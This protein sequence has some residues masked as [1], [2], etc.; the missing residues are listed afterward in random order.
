MNKISKRMKGRV[1]SAL[2]LMAMGVST[3][4]QGQEVD[5]MSRLSVEQTTIATATPPAV[6][7]LTLG[8]EFNKARYQQGEWANLK[9]RVEQPTGQNAYVALVQAYPDGRVVQLFPNQ[10][11]SNNQVMGN[12]TF[13]IRGARPEGLYVNDQPG[14]YLVKLIAS[15]DSQ[16]LNNV[17]ASTTKASDLAKNLQDR[18]YLGSAGSTVW[19]TNGIAYEVVGQA[20]AQSPG[21]TS[22]PMAPAVQPV[23]QPMGVQ[24]ML[25]MFDA[26]QSDFHVS[27]TTKNNQQQYRVGDA[28]AFQLTSENNC[29]AGL[30]HLQPNGQ[31]NVLYP[32]TVMEKVSLKAGRVTWLPESED[33]LQI[34]ADQPG[35]HHFMLACSDKPNFFEWIFGR[36]KAQRGSFNVKPTISVQELLQDDEDNW[37]AYARISVNVM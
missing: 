25:A 19:A 35:Q 32:N 13:Y 3:L 31:M 20:V 16:L 23:T 14:A 1:L 2:A 34:V 24:G 22:Q 9:V 36:E 26:K 10:Y 15:T 18:A 7:N 12:N 28:L 6:G 21:L 17:L 11:Q 4:V 30:I 5:V 8:G 27:I 33:G 29:E 37:E